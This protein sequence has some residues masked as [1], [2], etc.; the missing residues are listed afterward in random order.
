MEGMDCASCALTIENHLKSQS[1]VKDVNVNFRKNDQAN[2]SAED[3]YNILTIKYNQVI[4]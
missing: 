1:A 2:R 4:I 3:I